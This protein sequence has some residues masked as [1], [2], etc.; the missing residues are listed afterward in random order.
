MIQVVLCLLLCPFLVDAFKR[1]GIE[2]SDPAEFAICFALTAFIFAALVLS[3]GMPEGVTLQYSGAAFLA[4]TLGYCRALLSMTLLLLITQ[5]LATIGQAVLIDALMP[6]WLMHNLVA[7]TRRYLPAN[8]FVFLLGCG[9]FGLFI[10]YAM[11]EVIGSVA[12]ALNHGEPML[13]RVFSEPTVWG[14]LLA[15]GEATLEGMILTILV[16]YIPKA[17]ATFDDSFYLAKPE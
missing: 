5:P 15:S 9:F 13:S 8:L 2:R 10:V 1:S 16:V 14:L 17:V 4:L 11:Q 12:L 6:I 3:K 7:L